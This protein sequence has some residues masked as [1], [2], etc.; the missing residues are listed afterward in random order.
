MKLFLTQF[1]S[2]GRAVELVTARASAAIIRCL[3][4][5]GIGINLEKWNG[6]DFGSNET[7]RIAIWTRDRVDD[8]LLHRRPE[9]PLS[10]LDG[11]KRSYA[12]ST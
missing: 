10:H 8:R 2:A 6:N 12:F 3:I 9:F 11:G 7:F 5:N 4:L 1:P